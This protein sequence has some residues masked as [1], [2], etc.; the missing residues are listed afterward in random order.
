MET[1]GPKLRIHYMRPLLLLLFGAI[2]AFSQPFSYGVKAGVP[3]TDFVDA[4]SGNTASGFLDFATH[5]NRYIVGVTG[6]LRLP[7]GL[8][9][10]VDALY[11]HVN[12][13]S[14][15]GAVD[16]ITKAN[17]TGNAFEFPIMGKYRFGTK[18][19]HPFVDAGVAFDTLQG[20]K[21]A[22]TTAVAGSTNSTNS[23]TSTPSQLQ[24]T[25]T[26]GFVTGA[27][28]DFHFLVIHIQP[29]IR[30]TRWGA[31]HFLDVSGLLH[32]NQNQAEFLLGITF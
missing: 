8:G 29:E 15:S 24:N 27:G 19:I 9:V 11:R 25:T 18:V 3:L 30:Y 2:P 1:S 7:F 31:Q 4:A 22:I 16:A 20:L 12:Y 28:L 17:T 10:E 13:Q 21:Q 5:T 14:T 26:R 23:S 6:E 32:S